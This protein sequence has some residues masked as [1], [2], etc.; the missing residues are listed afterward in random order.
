MRRSLKTR[1]CRFVTDVSDTAADCFRKII[2][3]EKIGAVPRLSHDG[4]SSEPATRVPWLSAAGATNANIPPPV[5]SFQVFIKLREILSASQ[6][7]ASLRYLEEKIDPV[8]YK[9]LSPVS[10]SPWRRWKP[11]EGKSVNL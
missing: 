10:G 11:V 7:F 4:R 5:S 6:P 3:V 2:P 8:F 9:T 1:V